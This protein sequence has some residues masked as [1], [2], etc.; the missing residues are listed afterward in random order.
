MTHMVS[1]QPV[2]Y[3]DPVFEGV[4]ETRDLSYGTKD[5]NGTEKAHLF[6]LYQPSGDTA[7]L[8]PLIIWMHGGGFR[9]GSKNDNSNRLWGRSFAKRGYV[10]AAINYSLSKKLPMFNFDELKKS[11]YIA[12]VDV[13]QAVAYFREHSKLY[14]IDP[15]KIIIGGNSAGGMTAMQAAYS[16]DA[17]LAKFAGVN[18][19]SA[20]N[21]PLKIA[22][23]INFWGAIFNLDWLENAHVPVVNVYGLDDSIVS[24]THSGP[25]LF[26]GADIHTRA[27][28]E[29]IA[30]D[31]KV[32]EGYSHELHKH[33]NSLFSGGKGTRERWEE[34]SGFA[35]AFIY[36][37]L[38]E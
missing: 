17:E 35:A 4:K 3:K 38:F 34:A 5:S 6:D 30:N 33:F 24:P 14:H 18:N 36:R 29:G 23:V 1:A 32:F 22:A 20:R 25:P 12:V 26:G 21:T 31:V 10:F 19:V 8:R 15:D 27:T 28:K 2:R 16:T 7:A 13:K 37:E 9:F 11:C